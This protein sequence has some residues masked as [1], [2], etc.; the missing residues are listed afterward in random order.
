[1]LTLFPPLRVGD[2]VVIRTF[3]R[4]FIPGVYIVQR[5]GYGRFEGQTRVLSR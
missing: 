5:I 1:M 2:R 4:R 3:G